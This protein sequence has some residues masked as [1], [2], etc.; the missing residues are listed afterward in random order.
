[1]NRAAHVRLAQLAGSVARFIGGVLVFVVALPCGVLVHASAPALTRVVVATANRA[2]APAFR[3]Q[4][5]VQSL[6]RF[7]LHGV[8]G[9]ALVVRDPQGQ[10]VATANGVTVH[11]RLPALAW[12]EL[13]GRR[14]VP[15]VIDDVLFRTI[16]ATLVK[17]SDGQPTLALAFAPRHPTK[18]TTSPV[19]VT[20]RSLRGDSLRVRGQLGPFHELTASAAAVE[21]SFAHDD[22][23]TTAT[24]R[25][26]DL[27]IVGV[28]AQPIRTAIRGDASL[29][30]SGPRR[31]S[32]SA[33][34]SIGEVPFEFAGSL[35]GD[36]VEASLDVRATEDALRPLAPSLALG[37]P[38]S[39]HVELHGLLT[40]AHASARIVAAGGTLDANA[41]L[42]HVDA[43]STIAFDA[44]AAVPNLA[45]VPLL[46]ERSV[47]GAGTLA[48]SGVVNLPEAR[49]DAEL[50]LGL[51]GARLQDLAAPRAVAHARVRGALASPVAH[52][53]FLAE[54]VRVAGQRLDSVAMEA[55]GPLREPAVTVVLKGPHVPEVHARA[56]LDLARGFDVREARAV[57]TRGGAQ[58]VARV[59]R[60][61]TGG[62]AVDV[63]GI[64]VESG[65]EPLRGEA[66]VRPQLLWMRLSTAGMRPESGLA[67]GRGLAG[68]DGTRVRRR[69]YARG[70]RG[71]SRSPERRL[72]GCGPRVETHQRASRAPVRRTASR[73]ARRSRL[74]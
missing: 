62:G 45:R 50:E 4:V 72:R 74:G 22:R 54:G 44:R 14:D 68:H 11:I 63:T 34:G 41:D 30:A 43:A 9:A 15:I 38:A 1:M 47:H 60:I 65:G 39:A 25:R 37:T 6:R 53:S 35:Q 55:D 29:P 24:V 7:G 18:T 19:W 48:S 42:W 8:E 52:V 57:L 40:R 59:D 13:R 20:L 3:G 64:D 49:I 12:A 27:T 36:H 69:R 71:S 66:H 2:M 73:R 58:V 17:G 5:E 51:A 21:A 31:A 28:A 61:H 26:L 32:A 67:T 23:G 70:P 46:R 56:T 33:A 10:E 16:E